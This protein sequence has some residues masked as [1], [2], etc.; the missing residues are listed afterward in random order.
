LAPSHYT[1][2]VGRSVLAESSAGLGKKI[3]PR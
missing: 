1:L 3:C 2:I